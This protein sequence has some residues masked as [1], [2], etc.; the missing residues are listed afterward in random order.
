MNVSS[1]DFFCVCVDGWTG[2]HCEKKVDY[3]ANVTCKNGG[4]CRGSLRD[5][6]YECMSASQSGRFCETVANSLVVR[7]TVNKSLSYLA[8]LFLFLVVGLIVSMDILKYVFLIDPVGDERERLWREKARKKALKRV[9]AVR[10]LYVHGPTPVKQS[11]AQLELK[12]M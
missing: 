6:K 2:R 1:T 10:Y 9:V 7:Q 5:F 12:S 4:V 8:I 11:N 3:C